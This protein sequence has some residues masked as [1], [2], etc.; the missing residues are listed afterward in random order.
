MD[1][2]AARG[3]NLVRQRMR[4]SFR[5]RTGN[6]ERHVV[7]DVVQTDRVV[8]DGNLVYGD[9]LEGVSERNRAGRF[10]GYRSFRIASQEL[11][12]QAGP[13]VDRAIGDR[14]ARL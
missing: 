13:I 10:K 12:R 5:Q 1:D 6:A 7:T 3:V 4:A 14:M 9:W 8:H 11:D 2:V